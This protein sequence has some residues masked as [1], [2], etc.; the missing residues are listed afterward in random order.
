MN[1]LMT[2]LSVVFSFF[3]TLLITTLIFL[4]PISS[5]Y[6]E[7][8]VDINLKQAEHHIAKV[9]IGFDVATN[10]EIRFYLPSWRTGRYKIIN[11]ANG[12][13]DFSALDEQGNALIW[14]KT[15]KDTWQITGTKGKK[16]QLSYQ[17]YA[18]QLADRTRHI[19][20]THAFIDNSTVVMYSDVS[21]NQQHTLSLNVPKEWRSVSGLD[22]V[23][24]SGDKIAHQFTAKNYDIL[25]D[26]PIETGIHQ[27]QH[28][29]VDDR[30]Y[31]LVIWGKGN[32]EL[33][34]I[35]EDL[36]VLVQQS[37][38]IWQDYP[39]KRYVFMVHATSGAR[40]ATE[41][42]NSTIIQRSRFKFSNRKDYLGFITTAAHEFVHTW[43]VKQYRPEGLV[44]Y[45][46]QKENYDNLLWL[47]EGSTSYLQYQLLLRGN[48][49]TTKEFLANLAKRITAFEHKPG[50]M[51]QTVAQ[52]GFDAWISEGGDYANNHSVNIY[53]EGFFVSWLL[54][55]E[56]LADSELN[57]SYRDVHNQLSQQF[58][59]PKS[60]NE[61][62]ILAILKSL[63]GKSYHAWWQKNVHGVVQVDFKSLLAQAGLFMS[64]QQ[65]NALNEI[66]SNTKSN[67]LAKSETI[68]WSGIKTKATPSG[69]K[70]TS[71]ER[72]SPA[73][74]AGLTLDDII[75][76]VDGLRI[77]DKD[78]ETRLKNFQVEQ[79][80]EVTFFR[81]DELMT[82]KVNLAAIAK[83]KLTILPL[84]KVSEQQRAFFKEWTGLDFPH[85]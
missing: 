36:K 68:A 72:N 59:L 57:K 50:R 33:T 42:V 56:L 9:T 70:I 53:S 20:D 23:V 43:N 67:T 12:I 35:A 52:A 83:N 58:S 10:D 66:G 79:T 2:P 6:A 28:F 4:A 51:S 69:L 37:K 24:V 7:V 11:L 1:S 27:Y 38:H 26:S 54:D 18:N 84:P 49:I 32:Y 30:D 62:D 19:D 73:W 17:V 48:L 31:D 41:H 13:R 3:I 45:D 78:L 85:N 29:T 47:A 64:N 14:R 63:T 61:Q 5:S 16:V 55:F 65:S 60:Y 82:R 34:K 77:V 80:I 81:R 44:P 39:F 15:A 21:R 22:S 46:Y 25:A 8:S 75:V 76:A 74:Q 40:G 71:V